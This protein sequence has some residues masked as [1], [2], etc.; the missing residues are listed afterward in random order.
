MKVC[1]QSFLT[2]RVFKIF[3][4]REPFVFENDHRATVLCSHYGVMVS[5]KFLSP[6]S[7][8]W[9]NFVPVSRSL[10]LVSLS[11]YAMEFEWTGLTNR[12]N[13][14]L[15]ESWIARS[16]AQGAGSL[17]EHAD[18]RTHNVGGWLHAAVGGSIYD[19][20]VSDKLVCADF[21]TF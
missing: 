9:N 1:A 8:R 11:L 12:F 16:G 10:E 14:L 17:I 18:L 2:I 19:A 5:L 21:T 7:F 20:H 6:W 3:I 13:K 4:V 15:Y